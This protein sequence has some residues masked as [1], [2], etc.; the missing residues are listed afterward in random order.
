MMGHGVWIF[1]RFCLSDNDGEELMAQRGVILT[2]GF[3]R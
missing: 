2:D 1:C 3:V